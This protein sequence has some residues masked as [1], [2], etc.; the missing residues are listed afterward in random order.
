MCVTYQLLVHIGS[1]Q[2]KVDL[3]VDTGFGVLVVVLANLGRHFTAA[4]AFLDVLDADVRV[5]LVSRT[6]GVATGKVP[7]NTC[8]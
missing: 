5:C 6:A 3:L 8:E 2:F 7:T 4:V 1:V